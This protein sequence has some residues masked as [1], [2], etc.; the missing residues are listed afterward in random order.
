MVAG[1]LAL[2]CSRMIARVAPGQPQTPKEAREGAKERRSGS[3]QLQSRYALLA[4]AAAGNAPS[5]E[6]AILIVA[7][8]PS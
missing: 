4:L 3:R 5:N 6:T 7:G 2:P 1:H 8:L